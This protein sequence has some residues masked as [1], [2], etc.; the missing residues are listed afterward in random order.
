MSALIHTVY[1]YFRKHIT[2]TTSNMIPIKTP[3]VTPKPTTIMIPVTNIKMTY[4]ELDTVN[5]L[6]PS[7]YYIKYYF[8][9][10]DIN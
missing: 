7:I 2:A 4:I 8:T 5:F 1:T 6:N 3:N 10:N 9:V